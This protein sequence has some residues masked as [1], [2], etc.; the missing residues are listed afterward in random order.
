MLS[1]SL[2]VGSVYVVNMDAMV[3]RVVDMPNR[4]ARTMPSIL[5]NDI[6]HLQ[7]T[8]MTC[9]SWLHVGVCH[10]V[11]LHVCYVL[12]CVQQTYVCVTYLRVG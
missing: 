7:F 12:T 1:A 8:G 11:T 10:F 2:W 9:M 3:E 6:K 4:H 5:T